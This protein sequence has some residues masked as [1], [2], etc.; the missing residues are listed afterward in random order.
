MRKSPRHRRQRPYLL[1]RNPNSALRQ[2]YFFCVDFGPLNTMHPRRT[3]S[4]E[5]PCGEPSMCQKTRH[6]V[7]I[8]APMRRLPKELTKAPPMPACRIKPAHWA[9]HPFMGH[10]E[11]SL[12]DALVFLETA[13]ML[14]N[15]I[16][17]GGA[18]NAENELIPAWDDPVLT[19]TPK[20]ITPGVLALCRDIASGATPEFVSVRTEPYAEANECFAAVAKKVAADGGSIQHGWTIWQ[21]GDWMAEGEF[22]AVW[23]SPQGELVDISPKPAGETSILFLPDPKLTYRGQRRDNWRRPLVQSQLIDDYITVARKFFL[24]FDGANHL[25]MERDKALLM[26]SCQEVAKRMLMLGASANDACLCQSGRRYKNCH[27]QAVKTIR[28]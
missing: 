18:M 2:K 13:C 23:R 25:S 8:A 17:F 16:F 10:D 24:M 21:F 4:A 5:A 14:P 12:A 7:E 26:A 27:G 6:R 9:K 20:A 3:M 1:G 22:H 28:V 11:E 15:I 19:T